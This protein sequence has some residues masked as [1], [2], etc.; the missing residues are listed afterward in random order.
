MKRREFIV[1]IVGAV[2]AWPPSA[3]AQQ[4]PV[5]VIGYLSS[6]S[7]NAS[8]DQ[9]A[10]LRQGLNETGFFDGRNILIE[11]RWS[12][13]RYDRLPEMA[14]ELVNNHVSTILAGGLPAV[15]AAKRAS[16]SIPIVFV[17]GA[18]PVASGVVASLNRPDG[19]VTGI[20]Q[21]YGALG[22]KRLELLRE[23]VPTATKIA[24]LSDPNN[25]NAESHLN[26]VREAVHTIG[27]TIE[28][29]TARTETEIEAA[30][31]TFAREKASAL[32]VTDDPFYTV[33]REQI[34]ALA[35]RHRI[36]AIYY[37]RGF[38]EAGGLISYGS[39][40]NDNFHQAGV[41]VGRILNGTK[42]SELPVLQP[43]KFEMVLNLKTAKSLG[44]TIPQSLLLRADEV[45]E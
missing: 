44:L 7:L 31:A 19:N 42:P 38:A 4:K 9:L 15:L 29:A 25:P 28:V 2:A 8:T 22:G 10:G 24:V 12:E 37:V 3:H 18:D 41:Y 43:T 45:I 36:P 5:S 13:G 16:A 17:I 34:V 1:L 11:Y 27:Q 33:R 14:A 32:L 23:I 39:S 20:S 26:E 40:T 21:F 30:F 35:A 6:T